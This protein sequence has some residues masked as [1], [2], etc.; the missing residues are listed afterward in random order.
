MPS[1]RLQTSAAAA[2]LAILACAG[3]QVFAQNSAAPN[4]AVNA[5]VPETPRD[6]NAAPRIPGQNL[7]G[8]R[9]YIRAGL[10]THGPGFHDYPQFLA[11]WSKVLTEKGAV[12]DGSY[13]FPKAE[14]LE[15]VDVILMFKG[16]SGYLT[17]AEKATLEAF[18]RRGGGI[19][20]LH[21]SMCGPDPAYMARFVGGAKKHGETNFTQRTTLTYTVT[22]KTSPLVKGLS[23]GYTLDDEAFYAITWAQTGVKPLISAVMTDT[24]AT[25]RGVGGGWVGKVVPQMWT[26][27]H[28][29]PGGQP[30]RA[31]V[32]MQGHTQTN[33]DKPELRDMIL[34]GVA[35]AGKRPVDELV[36]YRQPPAPP[37]GGGGGGGEN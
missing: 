26:Y 34:R 4:S 12:V 5:G 19:V 29:L 37:R 32:W 33:F 28:S 15:G 17:A 14:E 7:K 13:H 1:K 21:D 22:D 24:A 18:V 9:V 27:E 36:D 11:D 8:M 2:A 31:F 16:D 25:R 6:P 30:A 35:W 23:D 3:S 20:A 10:K